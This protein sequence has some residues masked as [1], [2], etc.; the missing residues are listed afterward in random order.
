MKRKPMGLIAALLATTGV[1]AGV[2]TQPI[3]LSLTGSGLNLTVS[4]AGIAEPEAEGAKKHDEKALK[5]IDTYIEK[6]GGKDLIMSI[7]SIETSA[8]MDIPMAGMKGKMRI[9]AAQPGRMSTTM[10]LPGFGTIESGYDGEYGWENNPMSGPRLMDGAEIKAMSDQVDPN[11]AAKYRERYPTIEH[12]GEVDFK[13]QK[14]HKIRLVS[15]EGRE[16]I[17][18]YSVDT[19][20]MAGQESTQPSAMGEIKV[21]SAMSDYKE[22]GGMTMPTRV[23]QS[24]G[25]QEMI[26]TIE[27]VKINNVDPAVFKR[28][29]A[30]E[31]LIQSK[32]EG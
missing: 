18:Y 20:L 14:V 21:V 2:N 1:V 22:F 31:A 3:S 32:K 5:V 11:S 25:A 30:V 15:P 9:Y 16:S 26:M 12:Q 4:F 29:P 19:G 7:T 13:G 8:T 23:A 27:S 24:V 10:E 28:P 17:E 6:I